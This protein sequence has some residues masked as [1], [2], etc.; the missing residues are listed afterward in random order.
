MS[1]HLRNAKYWIPRVDTV[2]SKMQSFCSICLLAWGVIIPFPEHYF[3]DIQP[4]CKKGNRC[5]LTQGDGGS[6]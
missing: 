3:F 2:P 1:N 4:G 5:M 6:H